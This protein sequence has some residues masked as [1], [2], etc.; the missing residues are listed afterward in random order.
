M[1]HRK[2]AKPHKPK[3]VLEIAL[4]SLKIGGGGIICTPRTYASIKERVNAYSKKHL[5]KIR[6]I[7]FRGVREIIWEL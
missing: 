4:N 6:M 2:N 5:R 1:R 7:P 3:D